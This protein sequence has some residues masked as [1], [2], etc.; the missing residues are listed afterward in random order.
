M[1]T[2]ATNTAACQVQGDADV[3]WGLVA[4]ACSLGGTV[5][6][7]TMEGAEG[8]EGAGSAGG[9]AAA[10]PDALGAAEAASFMATP[11]QLK[12]EAHSVVRHAP[13]GVVRCN[14]AVQV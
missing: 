12:S 8:A 14:Q 2:A 6:L 10:Q 7:G 3:V 4:P 9:A 11:R 1:C 13:P 5:S